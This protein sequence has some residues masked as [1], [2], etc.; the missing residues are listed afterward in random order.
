MFLSFF[1]ALLHRACPNGLMPA[2]D[3]SPAVHSVSVPCLAARGSTFMLRALLTLARWKSR[4][5]KGER[6]HRVFFSRVS[7][8]SLQLPSILSFRE[9]R[10]FIHKCFL[11]FVFLELH[12]S[13]KAPVG[14]AIFQKKKKKKLLQGGRKIPEACCVQRRRQEPA[15]DNSTWEQEE[16]RLGK[17]WFGNTTQL[18]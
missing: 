1:P 15:G 7:D 2:T 9:Q 12:I 14:K 10:F 3:D 5:Q 11:F 13:V 16:R 6:L 4:E 8:G 18:N 17:I